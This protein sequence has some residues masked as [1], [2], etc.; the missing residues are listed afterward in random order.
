MGESSLPVPVPSFQGSER[1]DSSLASAGE[2]SHVLYSI[3]ATFAFAMRTFVIRRIQNRFP[4]PLIKFRTC[5]QAKAEVH[6][7]CIL[8][9]ARFAECKAGTLMDATRISGSTP[10]PL[11][12]NPFPGAGQNSPRWACG[13]S[14]IRRSA[15]RR[16]PAHCRTPGHRGHHTL[17]HPRLYFQPRMRP[18]RGASAWSVFRPSMDQPRINRVKQHSSYP[19]RHCGTLLPVCRTC[20]HRMPLAFTVAGGAS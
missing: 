7:K 13:T 12:R 2:R 4:L 17:P 18:L 8:T 15:F 9:I 10:N 3:A 1:R 6:L 5:L 11:P 19:G 20:V 16:S 14:R